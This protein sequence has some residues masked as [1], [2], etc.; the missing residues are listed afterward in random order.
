MRI[1]LALPYDRTA[2]LGFLDDFLPDFE[3]N[4]R[5]LQ[6]AG[7]IEGAHYLGKCSDLDVAVFELK[8]TG[9][10]EK[11]VSLTQDG[12]RLMKQAGVFRAL[13]IFYSEDTE[14]WRLSLMT[15]QPMF[16]HGKVIT[17]LSN[18][19]RYSY[20]LGPQAKVKTPAKFL[21]QQGAVK[22]FDDLQNRF[23]VEVVNKEFY[24]KITDLFTE[25]VG[26]ERNKTQYP[27]V[28]RLPGTN[29]GR[30][31]Q[32]FAV[33][34]IGRIIFCWFLREKKKKNGQPIIPLSLLSI[35]AAI[36]IP[37]Y[38]H[39]VLELL[40]FEILNQEKRT[41][42]NISEEWLAVPYLNGG[43]FD[44]QP[45]DYYRER[46][47]SE[48]IIPDS[49]ITKLFEV[50]ETYHF[51]VDENTSNDIDLSIDPE[52]LGRIFENLLAEINPET[53]K[54]ARN[55]TG[56]FYTP[57]EIVDYMVDETL[58]HY[59]H[60]KTKIDFEKLRALISHDLSD[61]EAYPLGIDEKVHIL[62]ALSEITIL[63]PACGSGAFP[64]GILQK[65]VYMLEVID[66]DASGWFELQLKK[67]P[68]IIRP[69]IRKQFDENNLGYV[70]KL[71][72]IN[73]SIHGVDIQPVAVEIA[74]LRCFLTLIVEEK[75]EES[76]DNLGIQPL[77][78]LDFKFVCTNTLIHVPESN[79]ENQISIMS[80]SQKIEPIIAD[81]F[82]ATG[83]VRDAIRRELIELIDEKV[84]ESHTL[85][86]S[87]RGLST[88]P[89]YQ[90]EYDKQQYASNS[91]ILDITKLW[92]SYKNILTNGVVGFYDT[93][94]FF[95]GISDGFDIVIG[96]PPYIQLQKN[97]GELANLYKDQGYQTFARTGDI[98]S[99]FYERGLKLTK[100][101]TGLLCYITSNKWMRAG[102][103]KEIRRFFASKNPII[104]I[105]FG[106][107]KVFESA[108]VDTNILLIQNRECNKLLKAAHFND[109]YKKQH[110]IIEYFNTNKVSLD[111]LGPGI[112]TIG[113]PA[114]LALQKKIEKIGKPLKEWN[115]NIF[116]GVL[117]GL[118]DAF[119]VD[120]NTKEQICREDPK[121]IEILKPILRG[122]DIKR[123]SYDWAGLWL[124]ASG[125]DV[126]VPQKYP[127]IYRH[128]L[129]FEE[130]AKKRGDKGKDW[131]NL[132]ACA[133]Y[134]EFEKEKVI[135]SE[136]VREPQFYLDLSDKLYCE[137]T[138]FIISGD[139]GKLLC[140]VLN[141][142]AFTYFFKNWYAGGGLGLSGIRYKKKFLELVPIPI[143]SSANKSIIKKIETEVEKILAI[144][145]SS[146][147]STTVDH[148]SK[149]DQL[150]YNL[151]ALT[152]NEI[153]IIDSS[154]I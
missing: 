44:P 124:I 117:T 123:Y 98:Y 141:S 1:D 33:R 27:G 6:P 55:S 132:R 81:Y 153:K 89:Q 22:D 19:R 83:A 31:K 59:L 21:I 11:R 107:F 154:L 15:A 151:Y 128:L 106:G 3:R 50:L 126:D 91:K 28:L 129:R 127:A 134:T 142:K 86:H 39:S 13:V 38:Y 108:T 69:I 119:I 76:E 137:A 53:G 88:L 112:W 72:V 63:D 148:E 103:G 90:E 111:D 10:I 79:P 60:S 42:E 96:N 24:K 5:S 36:A 105:D 8:H 146:V 32:Q 85:L 52:M 66:P 149:I 49:W 120:T 78:N 139:S 70:R 40:F 136:I 56:S 102:Y 68:A 152:P 125:F 20:A 140:G 41:K 133:Y 109:D 74:R 82:Q 80:F 67:A 51:T 57:R 92:K 138:S 43:L 144:K 135:Y 71:G 9:G 110:P 29:E 100:P 114:E 30:I 73:S 35:D 99:L 121:S 4:I 7:Q 93:K 61:D 131:W 95:P 130:K 104:L 12:F 2:I 23:S 75:V 62:E 17:T 64:I 34:M 45:Q 101:G 97:G 143:M 87:K 54:S 94:Y 37:E 47:R 14:Q 46:F 115:V 18:P 48:L 84:E 150:V 113:N 65:I 25:L 118:N 26:G 77:P 145:R 147:G 16:D 116:R 122:R 58:I